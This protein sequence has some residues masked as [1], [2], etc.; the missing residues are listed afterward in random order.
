MRSDNV[1]Q[2]NYGLFNHQEEALEK[3]LPLKVGALF[4]DMGT[5]KTRTML[6]IIDKK[7]KKGKIER[8]LWFCPC[9]VKTNLKKDIAKHSNNALEII[10]IY[11]IESV[12]QSNRIYVEI[13]KLVGSAKYMLVVDESSLVKNFFAVRSERIKQIATHCNYR[14]ILNGTPVT[15]NE[16]DLFSQF[17]IL[18]YRILGYMSFWAFDHNHLVYNDYGRVTNVKNVDYLTNKIAPYTYQVKKEDCLDLPGKYTEP[19]W[20]ELTQQQKYHY[21]ETLNIL[22]AEVDEFKEETIYTLLTALRLVSSGRRIKYEEDEEGF[23]HEP[24]FENPL[25]NPRIWAL[26]VLLRKAMD[27]VIIWTNYNYEIEEIKVLLDDEYGKDSYSVIHGSKSLKDR[28]KA[29]EEFEKDKTFL[30]ANMNVGK[31]GLNLQFCSHSIYYSPNWDWGARIQSE[32][33]IYRIG[34]NNKV[35]INEI[36]ANAGIDELIED[37]IYK[38]TDLANNI[39]VELK[40][41]NKL[42]DIL[43]LVKGGEIGDTYRANKEVEA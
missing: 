39:T 33:R 11:G 16:A 1:L 38:K 18:D 42:K 43:K 23:K 15:K 12:S 28:D 9:S 31:F 30:I 35:L 21:S 36:Y 40:D 17:Y 4:M 8:V 37:N 34:Q 3:I 19:F 14:Y 13:L 27:K 10:N 20:F 25:D 24:F 32:D 29:L 41:K 7:L 6:E 2:F 5:G 22:L 26:S